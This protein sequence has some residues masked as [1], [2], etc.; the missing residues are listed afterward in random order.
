MEIC[1][2]HSSEQSV[3]FFSSSGL[4]LAGQNVTMDIN[5]LTITLARIVSCEYWRLIQTAKADKTAS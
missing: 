2:H 4:I 1:I 3:K 5:G